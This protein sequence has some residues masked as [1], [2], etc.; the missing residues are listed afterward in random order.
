MLTARALDTLPDPVVA[1]Y[2]RYEDSVI[3]DIARRLARLDYARPTAAWQMQRLSESGAL[4]DSI[5]E[6]L[7]QLTGKSEA[8]LRLMFETAGVKAMRF[9]DSVY[10]AAGLNPLPLNLSPAMSQVLAAGLQKT[11]GLM[12]NLTMTTASTG[13]E[14]FIRGADLAYMQISSGAMDYQTAIKQAIKTTADEGLTVIHYASGRRDH[15][16][17]A[18]RRTVLTGVNQTVGKLQEARA[19]EMGA[20]LV[21]TSAHIGAR[22]THVEWQGRVFSRSGTHEQYPD[23]VS[24]TGYGTG[25]GLMGWNCRH[26]WFPFFEGI[27]AE[28]YQQAELDRY[29]NKEVEYN[30]KTL[31]FYEA[32]QQQRTIERRIRKAKRE[33]SALE[34]GGLD[35]TAELQKVR[36]YQAQMRDFIKQTD[37]TRQR[38]REQVFA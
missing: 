15:L 24:S 37:I 16:D 12:R 31:S 20:D 4:Y 32:T 6:R 21:Q 23:F 11:G 9:D 28:H 2:Q 18:M 25:P 19:N 3:N 34:A 33:A 5:L 36:F 13:Q 22:P 7:S 10:K 17:V 14:T 38:F 35:N 8:E 29:A 27:S 30:G 1:L 26:S